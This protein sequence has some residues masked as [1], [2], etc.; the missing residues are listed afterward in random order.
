MYGSSDLNRWLAQSLIREG[1]SVW[2]DIIGAERGS[3]L[4]SKLHFIVRISV[5]FYA[6][7][8]RSASSLVLFMVAA[9]ICSAACG[10]YR[11]IKFNGL[12]W[13]RM[14]WLPAI[15]AKKLQRTA[16]LDTLA[17]PR[18]E[19]ARAHTRETKG[20]RIDFPKLVLGRSHFAKRALACG[21]CK[22]AFRV[23]L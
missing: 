16:P 19:Q 22:K 17:L 6:K 8:S 20:R 11:G 14:R 5:T 7:V 15:P 18:S 4:A 13:T 3:V 21:T 1:S 23:P 10:N 2:R 12:P 9:A